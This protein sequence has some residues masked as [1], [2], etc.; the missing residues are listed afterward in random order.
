MVDD[1]AN[2]LHGE[3]AV[4][5]ARNLVELVV[6]AGGKRVVD[7]SLE[8]G[9]AGLHADEVVFLG[10]LEVGVLALEQVLASLEAVVGVILIAQCDGGDV[11]LLEALDER[12]VAVAVGEHLDEALLGAVVA[13]LAASLALGNPDGAFLLSEHEVHI[14]REL[15]RGGHGLQAA[16]VALDDKAL[17]Q[18]HELGDPVVDEQVVANGN[19]AR[20]HVMLNH[21]VAQQCRVENDVAVVGNECVGHI[22]LQVLETAGGEAA[23][24]FGEQAVDKWLHELGLQVIF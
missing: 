6:D 4:Q 13:V 22:F 12:H 5:V 21:E 8:L 7:M 24:G 19:F 10:L 23:R 15:Q 3:Q 11:Q 18:S 16:Q 17:V 14:A 1:V 20:V 9:N 2:A